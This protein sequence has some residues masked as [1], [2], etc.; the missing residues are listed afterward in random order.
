MYMK[1]KASLSWDQAN[2]GQ[3]AISQMGHSANYMTDPPTDLH[4]CAFNYS[5][6]LDPY[7]AP[8]GLFELPSVVG[9]INSLMFGLA[10]D[11]SQDNSREVGEGVRQFNG[12]VYKTT[13]HYATDYWYMGGAI[14][15]T[16]I[17]V[18][19][20]L[21][22]YWG[23]WQLGRKVTLNP[24]EIAYAFRSPVV[25]TASSGVPEQM[26][27]DVGTTKVKYGPIVAGDGRGQFGV[28]A[29]EHVAEPPQSPRSSRRQTWRQS[30][31]VNEEGLMN[32]M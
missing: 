26:I 29:P 32:V 5:N 2:G 1:G 13:V 24:F 28:S 12:T 27:K 16:V 11:I 15:S 6:P 22:I 8:N 7:K 17:C 30:R 10:T 20:V 23:F 19:L 31:P 3:Y 14:I 4:S 25:N 9:R 18:L 21:P